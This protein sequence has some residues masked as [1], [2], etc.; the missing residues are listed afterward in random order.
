MWNTVASEEV[1]HAYQK[2][3]RFKKKQQ[4]FSTVLSSCYIFLFPRMRSRNTLV[5]SSSFVS[6]TALLPCWSWKKKHRKM[7]IA[8]GRQVTDDS[9]SKN[10]LHTGFNLKKTHLQISAIT[11][12]DARFLLMCIKRLNENALSVA[13]RLTRLLVQV[14]TPPWPPETAGMGSSSPANPEREKRC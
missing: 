5:P 1:L 7:Q 3:Q 12:S 9:V 14:L 4:N 13:V 2:K 8:Q 10:N 6:L 11:I